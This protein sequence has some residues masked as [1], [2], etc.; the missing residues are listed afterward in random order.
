MCNDIIKNTSLSSSNISE[1]K[2]NIR[3]KKKE[4]TDNFLLLGTDNGLYNY[5][6][7][8]NLLTVEDSL[9]ISTRKYLQ[10]S[11]IK[12]IIISKSEKNEDDIYV[13]CHLPN[14]ILLLKYNEKSYNKFSNFTH[15]SINE[16]V[17]SI[18]LFSCQDI[19]TPKLVIGFSDK[20]D[21]C[22]IS[23]SKNTKNI[24]N[25][26]SINKKKNYKIIETLTK[27][28][29]G[30]LIKTLK[31]KDNILACYED[32]GIIIN[33]NNLNSEIKTIYWKQRIIDAGIIYN[34]YVV[35]CSKSIIDV[36]N[37][38]LGKIVHIFETKKESHRLLSLLITNSDNLFIKATDE[39]TDI[40]SLIRISLN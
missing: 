20:C 32:K 28:D 26:I 39:G 4:S 18:N 1:K 36:I 22:N 37:I 9:M 38:N 34:D 33:P 8:E 2:N 15:I 19:F 29:C 40:C 21:I 10:I 31:Y 23:Q 5:C 35:V 25:F 16:K 14:S 7:D 17:N 13:C 3:I 24:N 11:K 12:N 27:Y 6:L 30:K